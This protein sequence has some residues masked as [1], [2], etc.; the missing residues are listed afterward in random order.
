[1]SLR[2]LRNKTNT[3]VILISDWSTRRGGGSPSKNQPPGKRDMPRLETVWLAMERAERRAA[4]KASAVAEARSRAWVI[5]RWMAARWSCILRRRR[6]KEASACAMGVGGAPADSD[7]DASLPGRGDGRMGGRSGGLEFKMASL[8]CGC[9]LCCA[10]F[11][12]SFPCKPQPRRLV[13]WA[14]R[15]RAHPC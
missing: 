8:P 4:L 3:D 1:M 10:G 15:S 6:S 9:G 11:L 2:T 13:G 12:A 5:R 14:L 7:W